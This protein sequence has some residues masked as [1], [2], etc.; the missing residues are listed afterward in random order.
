MNSTQEIDF[1][2]LEWV[3]FIF[4]FQNEVIIKNTIVF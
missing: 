1:K 3:Y 4:L 2:T